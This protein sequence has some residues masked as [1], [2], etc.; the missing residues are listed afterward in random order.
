M[1]WGADDA[2]NFV[3]VELEVLVDHPKAKVVVGYDSWREFGA[4][5]NRIKSHRGMDSGVQS[6]D[7]GEI[8]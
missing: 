6:L 2:F 7:V 8:Q 5:D 3:Q 4:R 1:V